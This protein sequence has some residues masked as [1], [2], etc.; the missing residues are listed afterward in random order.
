MGGNLSSL[1][2]AREAVQK[3]KST[4]DPREM[5]IGLELLLDLYA[6][7]SCQCEQQGFGSCGLEVGRVRQE[8]RNLI[9][10]TWQ[11]NRVR[12]GHQ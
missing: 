5:A 7:A 12:A 1:E 8:I 2:V 10:D 11:H 4:T 3:L 6:D 9:L